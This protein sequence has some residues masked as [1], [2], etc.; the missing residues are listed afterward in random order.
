M[1]RG[2]SNGGEETKTW[3][4]SVSHRDLKFLVSDVDK[5]ISGGLT[6]DIVHQS[7]N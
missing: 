6:L 1:G 7:G 4:K 3:E 5:F 2:G